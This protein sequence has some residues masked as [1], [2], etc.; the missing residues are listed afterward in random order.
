MTYR[1]QRRGGVIV[2]RTRLQ[3]LFTAVIV[4]CV[5]GGVLS[6]TG[7]AQPAVQS[8][9]TLAG[10]VKK[11]IKIGKRADR[12]ATS[13]LKIARRA[14]QAAVA[15]KQGPAGPAGPQGERGAQGVAGTNGSSGSNG[16]AGA[17]GATGAA[18]ATGATG[19]QGTAGLWAVIEATGS[20]ATSIN[21]TAS[22]Q[23]RLGNGLFWVSFAPTDISDCAYVATV[24]SI[25][26]QSPPPPPALYVTVEQRTGIP[27]DLRLRSINDVGTLT[28]PG[29]GFGFHVA[30]FC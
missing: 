28:D 10:N 29:T 4:V 5:A 25:S 6:A 18:G 21:G 17:T 27:T 13:A 20:G 24:G 30:V 1:K 26:D 19:P 7:V 14:E 11:A 12:K 16:A 22:G 3:N 9:A 15:G 23:G 2:R 8:A